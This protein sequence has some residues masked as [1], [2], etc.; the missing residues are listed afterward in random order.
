MTTR[1]PYGDHTAREVTKDTVLFYYQ[2]QPV[3]VGDFEDT[4]GK[5]SIV[6]SSMSLAQ[7]SGTR[8]AARTQFDGW[9]KS[10]F[11][12]TTTGVDGKYD[13]TKYSIAGTPLTYYGTP[14][15]TG[16]I[17]YINAMFGNAYGGAAPVYQAPDRAAV[18]DYAKSYVVAVTGTVDKTI[19]EKAVDAYMAAD[20][21]NFGRKGGSEKDPITAMKNTV[22]G[23]AS[24]RDIHTLRP[25]SVDEMEW[26]TGRQAKLRQLGVSSQRSEQLGVAQARV[27]SNDEALLA[28]GEMQFNSDTG[29]LL[30][31][32]RNKLQAA[33]RAAMG[34]I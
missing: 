32:Q 14:L 22:R 21:S 28:A 17:P 7:I 23:T 11:Y 34:L 3:T 5:G 25:E 26:V 18:E 12:N 13:Q 16:D 30:A 29:R 19:L 33:G 8:A 2:G 10:Q 1:D 4:F 15:Q 27:G 31:E 20:K 9:L 24:Y 6:N